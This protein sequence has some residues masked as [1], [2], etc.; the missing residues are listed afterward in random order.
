MP[1]RTHL[2]RAMLPIGIVVLNVLL[3][4]PACIWIDGWRGAFR[5]SFEYGLALLVLV[6][7]A[8]TRVRPVVRGLVVAS[9]SFLLLFLFYQ[10]AFKAFFVREPALVEDWRFSIN[11]VHF[12][13]EMTSASWMIFTWGCVIG[14]IA[15]IVLIERM[16]AALQRR[17]RPSR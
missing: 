14:S 2:R 13:S 1:M 10:H 12:L 5:L 17:L 7:I 8:G 15:L 6:A 11:L 16:F 9:Y 4:V 3:F